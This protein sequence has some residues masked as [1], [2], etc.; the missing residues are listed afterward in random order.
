[1]NKDN[2][3]F[4]MMLCLF[5]YIIFLQQCKQGSPGNEPTILRPDTTIVLDTILPPPVIV[6][7]PKQEVP[8]PQIIYVD[9]Q[10]NEVALQNID[11]TKDHAVKLYT[12]S[13]RD[14]NLTIYYNAVVDGELIK[15]QLDYKLYVPKSITKTIEITKPVPTPASQFMFNLG[16]G[17][18][19]GNYASVTVGAAFVHKKGWAIGYD[20][21]VLQNAHHVKL[22]IKLFQLK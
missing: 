20:Y 11:T 3:Q 21:D 9:R 16:V 6:H 10:G 4:L 8:P 1:M 12:D 14:E 2:I 13:L 7:L 22:G 18:K 17:G 15:N 19:F 5:G